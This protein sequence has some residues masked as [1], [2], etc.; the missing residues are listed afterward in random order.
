MNGTSISRREAQVINEMEKRD[1]VIFTPR[2]VK[3]FLGVSRGNAYRIINSM[4]EKGLVER[5]ER[6]KYILKTRFDELDVLEV[7]SDLF[8][9]SYLA[10]W[11]ALHFHGM[12]DQVPRKIFV[13]TTK[14]KR[15][16]W[17]QGQETVYI[18]IKRELFFGYESYGKV[19]AS[20]REKTIIDCLR[21]PEYAGGVVQISEAVDESLDLQRLLEYSQ[22]TGSS[23][24]ASRL[25][26]ILYH[27]GLIDDK[28]ALKCMIT[29]YT[30]LDPGGEKVNPD[31]RWKI[32]VNR[33]I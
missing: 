2:D 23:A 3:H 22:R 18:T 14:R 30:K 8:S 24:V 19:I 21:Q 25:G 10:F 4:E 13:A 9:P 17:L 11:S 5:I 1:V 7:V 32:Y 27:K 20:D 29:T 26:Y 31:S 12:T 28:D 33:G 16:L 15:N 6:G